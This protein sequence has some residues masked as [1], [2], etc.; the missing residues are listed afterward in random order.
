MVRAEASDKNSSNSLSGYRDVEKEIS[1][2]FTERFDTL[3]LKE[4]ST[5]RQ[6]SD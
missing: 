6:L 2:W 5:A 4:R 3:A 1:S